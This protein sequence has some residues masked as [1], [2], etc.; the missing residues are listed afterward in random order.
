MRL[1]KIKLDYDISMLTSGDLMSIKKILNNELQSRLT[2][3]EAGVKDNT[4]T[5]KEIAKRV[6]K[7]EFT[8]NKLQRDLKTVSNKLDN[9]N[10]R[11]LK[12]VIRIEH[13]LKLPEPGFA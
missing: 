3:V 2:P 6:I 7:I 8:T 4:I 11:T 13:H 9:D 1:N 12:R 10:I 5:L